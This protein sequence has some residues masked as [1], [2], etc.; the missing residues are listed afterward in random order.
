MS[1]TLARKTEVFL[2]YFIYGHVLGWLMHE[3]LYFYLLLLSAV[4]QCLCDHKSCIARSRPFQEYTLREGAAFCMVD[5]MLLSPVAASIMRCWDRVKQGRKLQL[6]C[7]CAMFLN[8]HRNKEGFRQNHPPR[9]FS[10]HLLFFRQGLT[11][12]S[13]I[14]VLFTPGFLTSLFNWLP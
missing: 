9:S 1:D 10:S 4:F 13:F 3:E 8:L 5:E 12:E 11:P 6:A 7:E 14:F 2:Q